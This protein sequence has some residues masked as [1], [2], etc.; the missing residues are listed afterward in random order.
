MIKRK[1]GKTVVIENVL[2]VPSMKSNLL[3]LGQLLEKGF[4]MRTK[5]KSLNIYDGNH[6]LMIKSSLIANRI[7]KIK[8]DMAEFHCMT[9]ATTPKDAWLW[10][11]RYGHLNFDS[12]N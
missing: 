11:F 3:S 12:L 9:A 8:M 4:S 6:H 7:F 5:N 1:N 10:H 2:Y